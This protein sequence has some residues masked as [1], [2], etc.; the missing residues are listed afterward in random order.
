MYHRVK[1]DCMGDFLQ[2]TAD[3]YIPLRDVVFKTLRKAIL[4]GDLPPGERLLE[5]HL[6]KRMGVSRTPIREAIRMLELEGLVTMIPRRGAEVSQI[7][8]KGLKD[9]LEVRTALDVMAIELS[10]DRMSEEQLHELRVAMVEFEKAI[11]SKSEVRMAQADV[12]FHDIIVD[13]TGN[14]K[15]KQMVLNLSEQVYRYRYECVK[16]QEM[17]SELIREHK[18]MYESIQ[19][20]DKDRAKKAVL[21]HIKKQEQSIIRKLHL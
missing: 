11:R 15:L 4:M 16:D 17:H 3:E 18:E 1:E 7:T 13:A 9:V 5:V 21:L 8:S 2:V 14:E 10:C 6:A 20:K 19:N 12:N